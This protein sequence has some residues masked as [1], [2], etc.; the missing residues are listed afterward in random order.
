MDET[1]GG[2]VILS[3]ADAIAAAAAAVVTAFHFPLFTKV[4]TELLL[5][6]LSV[7]CGCDYCGDGRDHDVV[8]DCWTC[9]NGDNPAAPAA[10]SA[11]GSAMIY[12]KEVEEEEE[13][14]AP[15]PCTGPC[16]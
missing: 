12:D 13:V 3:A 9:S 10:P 5:P 14:V 15:R 1:G 6:L 2:E 7:V 11:V 4:H 16:T 8:R